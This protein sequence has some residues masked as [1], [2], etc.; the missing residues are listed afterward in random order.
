M[1]ITELA[2][3]EIIVY[4]LVREYLKKKALSSLEEIIDFL[5][6]RLK[7]NKNFNRNKILI[8]LKAI[9]KKRLILPGSKLVK[10][11]ILEIPKRVEILDH[12]TAMPG[13]GIKEIMD[14]IK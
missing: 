7:S 13:T 3:E 1:S 12:I 14:L 9:M 6:Q 10:E 5:V 4:E 2:E 11:D 8:I